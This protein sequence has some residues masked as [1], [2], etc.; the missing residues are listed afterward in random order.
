M[1]SLLLLFVL[2]LGFSSCS[3][4]PQLEEE[5]LTNLEMLSLLTQEGIDSFEGATKPLE[6]SLTASSCYTEANGYGYSVLDSAGST[7]VISIYEGSTLIG[8]FEATDE[9]A[10]WLCG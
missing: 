7:S 4:E 8:R 10:D 5:A 3:N 6:G 1:R 9:F 2:F